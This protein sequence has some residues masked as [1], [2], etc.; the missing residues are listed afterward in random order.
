M[1]GAG[2]AGVGASGWGRS[3]AEQC[4]E[5]TTP[6]PAGLAGSVTMRL[7]DQDQE[8]QSRPHGSQED[9]HTR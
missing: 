8:Q 5:A 4:S 1:G 3:Q 6:L 7:Q 2:V 9:G